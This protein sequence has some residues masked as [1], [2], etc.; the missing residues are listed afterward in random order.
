MHA[1]AG[2]P[3]TFYTTAVNASGNL[4]D[5][6][7]KK[8]VVV[9][10]T[11]KTAKFTAIQRVQK[12]AT[13]NT[14]TLSWQPSKALWPADVQLQYEILLYEGSSKTPTKLPAGI[15]CVY[16]WNTATLTGLSPGTKYKF[17]V[18]AVA[19]V[20]GISIESL[21]GKVSVKTL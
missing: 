20:E 3:P 17:A 4:L 5:S 15:E 11:A 9:S 10:V 21:D 1:V 6:R 7:G 16:N 12:Q 18:R 13:S 19:T 14:V 8:D 2:M